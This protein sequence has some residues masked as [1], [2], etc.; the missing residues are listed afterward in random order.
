MTA[1]QEW[2]Q[3]KLSAR[4]NAIRTQ[5]RVAVLMDETN[6]RVWGD[7]WDLMNKVVKMIEDELEL[8]Q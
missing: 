7:A 2:R 8:P 6:D 1:E 3:L 5:N 4:A